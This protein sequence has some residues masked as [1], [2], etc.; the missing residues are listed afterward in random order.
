MSPD[1]VKAENRLAWRKDAS[2]RLEHS[3]TR[4]LAEFL[5][6]S[7]ALSLCGHDPH[8]DRMPWTYG[9]ETVYKVNLKVAAT[10]VVLREE[11]LGYFITPET[12][13]EGIAYFLRQIDARIAAYWQA[14]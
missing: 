3:R 9:I 4:T 11:I 13:D 5:A 14:N 12:H 8:P 2:V 10:G 1:A 6:L 7:A